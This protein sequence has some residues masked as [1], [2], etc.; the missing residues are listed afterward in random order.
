[1]DTSDHR[2]ARSERA[3]RHGFRVRDD[4]AAMPVSDA[5]LD[6]VE[7]FL[8]AACKAVLAGGRSPETMTSPLA[9]RNSRKPVPKAIK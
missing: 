4:L 9:A 3:E 5:E 6:V 7:A 2:L 1:M 8:L